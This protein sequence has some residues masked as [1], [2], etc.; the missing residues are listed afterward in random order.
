MGRYHFGSLRKRMVFG[1]A[2][3]VCAVEPLPTCSV[4][5]SAFATKGGEM[6]TARRSDR[7]LRIEDV[8]ARL[9]V[10]MQ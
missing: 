10:S 9:K 1:L 5:E 4:S 3:A 2:M 6:R 8:F 7:N